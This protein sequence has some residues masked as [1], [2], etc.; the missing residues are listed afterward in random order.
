MDSVGEERRL[1]IWGHHR[2][3]WPSAGWQMRGLQVGFGQKK[4]R[5]LSTKKKAKAEKDEDDVGWMG[6]GG[7]ASQAHLR[8]FLFLWSL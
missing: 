2:L 4:H 3:K 5:R 6:C 1:G 7:F 8:V